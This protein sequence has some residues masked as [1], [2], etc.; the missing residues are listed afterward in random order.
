MIMP[1]T[2]FEDWAKMYNIKVKSD[3]CPKCGIKR[4]ANIPFAFK[5][6]RGLKS[7][8]HGCGKE[9][10]LHVFR[11]ISLEAIKSFNKLIGR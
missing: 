8:I 4:V 6:F 9:Y 1:V 2:N 10:V 7:E 5:D 11:P 3:Y